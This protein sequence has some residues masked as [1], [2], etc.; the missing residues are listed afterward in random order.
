MA[1]TSRC[2]RCQ[3]DHRICRGGELVHKVVPI[4]AGGYL[5]EGERAPAKEPTPLVPAKRKAPIGN[6]STRAESSTVRLGQPPTLPAVPG[7]SPSAHFNLRD[8]LE[9]FAVKLSQASR[10]FNQLEE[11]LDLIRRTIA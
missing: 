11:E 9:D 7:E 2:V 3:V 1:S 8:C 6:N 4:N 10:S 5:G